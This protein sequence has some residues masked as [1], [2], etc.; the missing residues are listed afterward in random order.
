M[1]SVEALR[2]KFGLERII[3]HSWAVSGELLEAG[4]N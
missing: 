2:A 1:R 3:L 4:R